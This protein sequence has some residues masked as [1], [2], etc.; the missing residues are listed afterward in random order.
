MVNTLVWLEILSYTCSWTLNQCN[1]YCT[2]T[3]VKNIQSLISTE[4]PQNMDTLSLFSHNYPAK[5]NIFNLS[6]RR[7][8]EDTCN[9]S[10]EKNLSFVMRKQVVINVMPKEGLATPIIPEQLQKWFKG[11]L[12]ESGWACTS[13]TFFSYDND[14]D[15]FLCDS[16]RE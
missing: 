10:R 13:Q 16:S 11:L 3:E 7:Q 5:L 4:K 2:C 6:T 12:I 14:K 8:T 1:M 9:M 15:L